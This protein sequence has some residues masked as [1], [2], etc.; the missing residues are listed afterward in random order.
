MSDGRN[1]PD[2]RD[3]GSSN[4]SFG[5]VAES[6][7]TDWAAL[8]RSARGVDI[9]G[10][11]VAGS[12]LIYVLARAEDP[13][14][15]LDADGRE[16]AAWGKGDLRRPHG[17]FVDDDLVYCV[18]DEGQRIVA[19]T[20]AGVRAWV[21]QGPNRAGETGYSPGYPRSVRAVSDPFCFPT[22]LA[23]RRD[24]T[25]FV[26]DGYGNAR[27]HRFKDRDLV[28]SYGQPGDGPG[29]FALPH[30]V[31]IDDESLLVADREN[32]RV[33]I[34]DQRGHMVREWTNVNC[35]NNIAVLPGGLYA[36]A[37]LG[38]QWPMLDGRKVR[39][40]DGLPP[41]VT[42]RDRSGSIV[43]DI[44]PPESVV[45][46]RWM[47]PHGIA[48]DQEGRIYLSEVKWGYTGGNAPSDIPAITRITLRGL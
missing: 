42:V 25:M 1:Q 14:R 28:E 16:L 46:R 6:W 15:V 8:P 47:A 32:E 9:P 37:E 7:Q 34:M 12:G 45:D 11:A 36:V 3:G 41:R 29:Q 2:G 26:S 39:D 13:V 43:A 22:G 4:A 30:G 44:T 21:I 19:Y 48:A 18:D 27:V 31:L 17:I 10:I 20:L 5:L 24:G 23:R 38:R 33:Q 40:D 35:P